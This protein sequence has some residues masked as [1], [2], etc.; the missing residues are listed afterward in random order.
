MRQHVPGAVGT[1]GLWY[2]GW[3]GGG[4]MGRGGQLVQFMKDESHPRLQIIQA[5]PGH[6]SVLRGPT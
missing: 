6:T 4:R 5:S 2:P 1:Q 3:G